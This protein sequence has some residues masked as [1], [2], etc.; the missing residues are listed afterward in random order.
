M[1]QYY[2]MLTEV[3]KNSTTNT[4]ML[5]HSPGAVSS[6]QEQ[7]ISSIEAGKLVGKQQ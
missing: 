4:I 5:P 1:T 3:G 2:D 7:I 6:I